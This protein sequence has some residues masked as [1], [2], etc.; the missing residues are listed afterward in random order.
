M[1]FVNERLSD[2]YTEGGNFVTAFY[3][4]YDP[5]DRRLTYSNAGHP[6]PRVRRAGEDW[7]EELREAGSLPLGIDAGEPY[8]DACVTLRPG[9]TLVLYTDGITEARTPAGA[10]FGTD[11]VDAAICQS[12]C[13]AAAVVADLLAAVDAFTGPHPPTDDRTLLVARVS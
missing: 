9:D 13:G 5:A 2:G 12:D 7:S 8:A 3:G 4:I 10:F 6:P 11:R 1:R